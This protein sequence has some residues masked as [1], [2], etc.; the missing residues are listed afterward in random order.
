MGPQGVDGYLKE[1]NLS[2]HQE[3]GKRNPAQRK[4]A[5][6]GRGR[7]EPL[8]PVSPPAPAIGDSPR[9]RS[10]TCLA[11]VTP[12]TYTFKYF[13]LKVNTQETWLFL[14]D[15]VLYTGACA[16][17]HVTTIILEDGP[18]SS[19][20]PSFPPF[21]RPLSGSVYSP[22]LYRWVLTVMV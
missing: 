19:K 9:Q 14:P 15:T 2:G 13:V 3:K 10:L 6:A 8:H 16:S 21:L 1:E 17:V 7:E 11:K 20:M 5:E 12:M 4:W 18:A 22:S